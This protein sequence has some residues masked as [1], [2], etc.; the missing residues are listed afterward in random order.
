MRYAIAICLTFWLAMLGMGL[1]LACDE[2]C[3]TSCYTYRDGQ[4]ICNKNCPPA[5]GRW[6]Y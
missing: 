1:A 2:H 5:W 3:T 4:T 6:R